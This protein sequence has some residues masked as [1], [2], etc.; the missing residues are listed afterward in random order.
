MLL[1]FYKFWYYNIR[2]G[3]FP[4][5]KNFGGLNNMNAIGKNINSDVKN[6]SYISVCIWNICAI[7]EFV[8]SIDTGAN[9]LVYNCSFLFPL[10]IT[11]YKS[12]L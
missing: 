8:A 5:N 4:I 10:C 1:F 2:N 6:N 12:T 9:I 3:T 7:S 11:L